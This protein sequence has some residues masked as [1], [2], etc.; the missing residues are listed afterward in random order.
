MHNPQPTQ[1]LLP[2][3]FQLEVL[4][5]QIACGVKKEIPKLGLCTTT[6]SAHG[7]A[8][9]LMIHGICKIN[10][11]E[12]DGNKVSPK[13][14]RK[15]VKLKKFP[16]QRLYPNQ[17]SLQQIKQQPL[18]FKKVNIAPSPSIHQPL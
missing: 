17:F 14:S 12:P 10:G 9:A 13:D 3:Y 4:Y 15:I 2:I 8:H 5:Q 18:N 1:A 7:I 16:A 11:A 6:I